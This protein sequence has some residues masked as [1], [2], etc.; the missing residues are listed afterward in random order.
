MPRNIEPVDPFSLWRSFMPRNWMPFG[1]EFWR[2]RPN[3]RQPLTDIID[4]GKTFRIV[5][6]LPG[7]EKKDISIHV[8]PTFLTIDA[9]VKTGAE[10][11]KKGYYYRERSLEAYHRSFSLPAPVI[12]E[13]T[14]ASFNNG[15]LEI[16]LTKQQPTEPK[17]KGFELKLK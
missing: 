1:E 10:E 14:Q 11:K 12:P 6:E 16:I 9:K 15:I 2:E 7:V 5:I 17:P 4:E 3:A 13:K 8:E